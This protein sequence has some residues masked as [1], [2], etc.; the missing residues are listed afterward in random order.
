MPKI[1]DAPAN[2][3]PS[4]G[5]GRRASEGDVGGF[6]R[7]M[8]EFGG[9][10]SESSMLL[11]QYRI[12]KENANINQANLDN[13]GFG[14]DLYRKRVKLSDANATDFTQDAL[15]EF[16]KNTKEILD[17]A[18]NA[19]VRGAMKLDFSRTR[20]T[21]I[22]KSTKFE[23]ATRAKNDRNI[24]LGN[25]NTAAS[26]VYETPTE[27]QYVQTLEARTREA[28][29][30]SL[31]PHEKEELIRDEV[32]TLRFAQF[33]GLLDQA[34]TPEEVDDILARRPTDE[35]SKERFTQLGNDGDSRKRIFKAEDRLAEIERNGIIS[36]AQASVRSMQVRLSRGEIPDDD[37]LRRAAELVLRAED[38]LTTEMHS[39]TIA[40]GRSLNTWLQLPSKDMEAVV[41]DLER[42]VME[43]GATSLESRKLAAAR[44]ALSKTLTGERQDQAETDDIVSQAFGRLDD[45][46][47]AGVDLSEDP[48]LLIILAHM[49]GA[50]P[51]ILQK[52]KEALSQNESVQGLVSMSIEDLTQHVDK[53]L[54]SSQSSDPAFQAWEVA[55]GVLADMRRTIEKNYPDMQIRANPNFPPLENSNPDSMRS[56]EALMVSGSGK[57]DMPRQFH[58]STEIAAIAAT[59]P[60]MTSDSQ[61]EFIMSYTKNMTPENAVIALTELGEASPQLAFVGAGIASNPAYGMT[62]TSILRGQQKLS[63][64]GNSLISALTTISIG[65]MRVNIISAVQDIMNNENLPPQHKAAVQSSA[66]ALIASGDTKDAQEAVNMVLGG[67]RDNDFGGVQEF[68]G[69][70]FAAPVGVNG[71]MIEAAFKDHTESITRLSVGGSR[72]RTVSGEMVSAETIADSGTLERVGPDMFFV[73]MRSDNRL[74]QGAPGKAYTLHITEDRLKDLDLEVAR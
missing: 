55:R 41:N 56:R 10:I 46:L 63:N 31:L 25:G 61:L 12:K 45:R 43:G 38:P 27:E 8:V 39:D 48:D 6:G 42:D 17:N 19:R 52:V 57:Y 13:Q 35:L 36:D 67:S 16:D 23:S 20:L 44:T 59:V 4:G 60:D 73:R 34:V 11:E 5:G 1:F 40:I 62:A 26:V 30:N 72:P 2:I 29:N 65:Q 28:M 50:S 47:R 54:E 69:R 71:G 64:Q 51:S 24:F 22:D 14:A 49:D 15:D 33:S 70:S 7:G 32:R 3:A 68:N 9:A 37:S 21:L 18:P 74:L 66:M 53:A 58:T